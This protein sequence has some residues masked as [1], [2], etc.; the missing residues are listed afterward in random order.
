MYNTTIHR[1]LKW[2]RFKSFTAT[3]TY[4]KSSIKTANIED[5]TP[6]AFSNEQNV[7]L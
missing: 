5:A 2:V 3:P 7:N 1:S 6:K 4:I